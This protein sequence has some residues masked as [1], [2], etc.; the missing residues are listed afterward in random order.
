MRAELV[1]RRPA[2]IIKQWTMYYNAT[3][4]CVYVTTV[5]VQRQVLHILNA[6][7]ASVIQHTNRMRCIILSSVACPDLPKFSTLSLKRQEFLKES[8]WTQN[9]C[10]DFIYSLRLKH[11]SFKKNWTRYDQNFIMLFMSSNRFSCRVLRKTWTFSTDS[12]GKKT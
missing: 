6:S 1:H 2:N 3:A 12:R 9:V 7:V 10:F 5:A 4:G 8:Y 11:F